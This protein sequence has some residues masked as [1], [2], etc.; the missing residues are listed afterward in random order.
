MEALE[1]WCDEEYP[2]GV[3][4]NERKK[5]QKMHFYPICDARWRARASSASSLPWQMITDSGSLNDGLAAKAAKENKSYLF[6]RELWSERGNDVAL[7][8]VA[9]STA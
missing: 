9:R 1:L 4:K 3:K 7:P 6:G 8:N 5:D 2:A